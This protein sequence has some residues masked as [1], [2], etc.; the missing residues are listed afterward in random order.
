M[1]NDGMFSSESGEWETPD[2]LFD[3]WN[4][5]F[6]FT[7]DVCASAENAKL[8]VY[9]DKEIDGLTQDWSNQRCWM[10]PPYGR[11]IKEWIRKAHEEA[12]RGATVVC[13]LPARTD[14]RWWQEYVTKADMIKFLPG[15]VKF[16]GGSSSAP[17]PSAIVVF[18]PR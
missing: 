1:I 13:L 18:L 9:F 15:R 4:R 17:F 5:I 12:G 16:K 10:N 8:S 11:P 14:T 2:D 6:T 7:V 3:Y